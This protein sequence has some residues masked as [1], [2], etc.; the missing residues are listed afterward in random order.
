M[1]GRFTAASTLNWELDIFNFWSF[2]FNTLALSCMVIVSLI[3]HIYYSSP[4]HPPIHQSP[5]SCAWY[6]S[7]CVC[8]CVCLCVCVRVCVRARTKGCWAAEGEVTVVM[9]SSEKDWQECAC[10][11]NLLIKG[12]AAKRM[13]NLFLCDISIPSSSSSHPLPRPQSFSPTHTLQVG[14]EN[15]QPDIYWEIKTKSSRLP[16]KKV[17]CNIKLTFIYMQILPQPIWVIYVKVFW[18]GE[19]SVF[20][21]FI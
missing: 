10:E 12:E 18:E 11:H 6:T 9:G 3:R 8:V 1:K 7:L 2:V 4:I 20:F 5:H 16:Y 21:S 17:I 14:R 15:T 19:V 13:G